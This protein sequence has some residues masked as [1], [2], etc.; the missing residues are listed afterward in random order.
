MTLCWPFNP[1]VGCVCYFYGGMRNNLVLNNY[2][3]WLCYHVHA[4]KD[5]YSFTYLFMLLQQVPAGASGLLTGELLVYLLYNKST[6][7]SL[8]QSLSLKQPAGHL[9]EFATVH[10][11]SQC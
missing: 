8:N 11:N 1:L 3:P 7:M 6:L 5:I 10:F 4:W 2:A 9:C